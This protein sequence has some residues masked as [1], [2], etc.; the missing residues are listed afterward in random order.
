MKKVLV[1]FLAFFILA[2][3]LMADDWSDA[4]T[5]ARQLGSQVNAR[6][7]NSAGV[8]ANFSA[9]LT[10]K[11]SPMQ[12]LLSEMYTCSSDRK[13]YS[14][15]SDC[16]A[17][18][19]GGTCEKGFDA[20]LE[21]PSSKSFLEVDILPASTGD[22]GT[23][24]VKQDTDFDGNFDY[25]YTSPYPVSGVCANGFISCDPG[26][27]N[28][29]RYFTW[30]ADSDKKVSVSEQSSIE[31]LGGCFCINNSCGGS[32]VWN[33][34]DTILNSLG[35]GAV[36]AIQSSDPHCVVT[37]VN[38]SANDMMITY[39]GQESDQGSSSA[40]TGVPQSGTEHPEVYMASPYLLT[41]A[42]EQEKLDQ[43]SDPN[44]LTY[45]IENSPASQERQTTVV[46]C[47]VTND[48]V[49]QTV[50]TDH[51][52]YV[53]WPDDV[54]AGD[55]HINCSGQGEDHSGQH[56]AC[57][58]C[59]NN[60]QP[61]MSTEVGRDISGKWVAGSGSWCGGLGAVYLLYG[62]IYYVWQT[63]SDTSGYT[64]ND[65]CNPD[66]SCKLMEEQACDGDGNCVYTWRNFNPTG[67]KPLPNCK[68]EN[69]DLDTYTVCTDGS[70]ITSQ[71]ASTGTTTTVVTGE[72]L[73]W[74]IKRKY[75][76]TSDETYDLSDYQQRM[77]T[78]ESSISANDDQTVFSYNDYIDGQTVTGPTTS[79]NP[80]VSVPDCEQVCEIKKPVTKTDA[81]VSGNA[82]QYQ[83]DI[84][85]Y[86]DIYRPCILQDDQYVCPVK[87]GETV[88]R[89]CG[90]LNNFQKAVSTLQLLDDAS[91]DMI[92]SGE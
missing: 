73:W 11:G 57:G 76:C 75:R 39:Y 47:Q 24:L 87:A 34:L 10:S 45:M 81:S 1:L 22:I 43:E 37:K 86:E 12:P 74:T 49:W 91:K 31:S 4:Q 72:N 19:S 30:Q 67:L 27:W 42:G 40:T 35:G 7:G 63:A 77:A 61:S 90:C 5:S 8:T 70:S 46:E 9:P 18:C 92:C 25:S 66:D 54:L 3:G 29:C 53:S 89:S 69:S 38:V 14:S 56:P 50:Y 60:T 88:V 44:S 41:G 55:R 26:T 2:G 48:V 52:C 13:T 51:Y 16:Q 71:A 68:T 21:H 78:I 58:Q 6:Y 17:A 65:T 36:S 80:G 84:T 85:T 64:H 15:L 20:Q 33:N 28:D 82:S 32:L 59:P 83:R 23:L 79:L 62:K